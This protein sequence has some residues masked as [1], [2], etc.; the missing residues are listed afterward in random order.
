[1]IFKTFCCVH[2]FAFKDDIVHLPL[3]DRH[4]VIVH[5]VLCE[6]LILNA[7]DDIYEYFLFVHAQLLVPI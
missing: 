4:S 5:L 6:L 2:D 1:M 3:C 7:N